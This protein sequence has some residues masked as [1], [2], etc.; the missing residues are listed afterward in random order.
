MWNSLTDNRLEDWNTL[1]QSS[2][3]KDPR[4]MLGREAIRLG[5]TMS[6]MNRKESAW[7]AILLGE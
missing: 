5:P 3:K 2:Y 6:E 1:I 7:V 4:T